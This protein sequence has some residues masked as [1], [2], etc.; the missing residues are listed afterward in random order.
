[1]RRHVTDHKDVG[2]GGESSKGV[3]VDGR[4]SFARLLRSFTRAGATTGSLTRNLHNLRRAAASRWPLK[5]PRAVPVREA[6][7][8]IEQHSLKPACG[9][10]HYSWD[11]ERFF[12]TMWVR[13]RGG[14][15]HVYAPRPL[16]EWAPVAHYTNCGDPVPLRTGKSEPL[17]FWFL[18]L[19]TFDDF[20]ARRSALSSRPADHF[21]SQETYPVA[22]ERLGCRLE[23]MPLLGNA[24]RFA[25]WYDALKDTKYNHTGDS[26]W[27]GGIASNPGVPLLWF[28][29]SALI[30]NATGACKAVQLGVSDER[31]L[32]GINI[33]AA[34]RSRFG[35][36][37][38]LAVEEIK[39]LCA[40]GANSFDCGISGN[41]GGYKR[42]IFLDDVATVVAPKQ[43]R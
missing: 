9:V 31:S 3:A 38:M 24:E 20:L 7:R 39:R 15:L 32:S 10:W 22:V 13:E 27:R 2:V 29:V 8:I 36:G 4:H 43:K 18:R 35:Y 11:I 34:R 37:V 16:N 23:H 40:E 5:R 41:Y 28:T 12:E 6:L 30:E 25:R 17:P 19:T 1:M 42:Q 21:P 14:A 33:A 26:C